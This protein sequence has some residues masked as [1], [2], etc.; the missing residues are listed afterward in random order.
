MSSRGGK[1]AEVTQYF[2]RKNSKLYTQALI[3]DISANAGNSR[4]IVSPITRELF[5]R[6]AM[7]SSASASV[8]AQVRGMQVHAH[9]SHDS[10]QCSEP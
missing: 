6:M 4:A 8:F 3:Q 9:E 10:Q 7:H 1:W 5:N 2:T